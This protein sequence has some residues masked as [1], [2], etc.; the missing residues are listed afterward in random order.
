MLSKLSEINLTMALGLYKKLLWDEK[1]HGD[2]EVSGRDKHNNYQK[3]TAYAY[4]KDNGVY[5]CVYWEHY[6][7]HQKLINRVFLKNGNIYNT[8][9]D[10]IIANY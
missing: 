8:N 9:K 4:Y 2:F 6:G 5:V 10:K 7:H 3:Y 1:N